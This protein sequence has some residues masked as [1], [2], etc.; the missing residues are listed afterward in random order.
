MHKC[1][2]LLVATLLLVASLTAC[3]SSNT[4]STNTTSPGGNST[5]AS[6]SGTG[7]SRLDIV[8]QRGKLICG[9]DGKIPGFSFVNE[10]GQ[11]SGLDVDVCKAVA[12]AVLGDPNAVEF[13]NLDSTERF[14]ALKAGEVDMLS[15]NTTWTISRDTSVGLEFAPTTFYDGQGMMVRQDSGIT[16]LEDFQGKAVCVE[17]GTTTELNLT[18]AMRQRGIQFETVTFQQADPAYAAY[19]EGRCQGMT[20]D[21]SQLVARRS[22]LPNPNEHILLDV[23]MSKEPLGPVTVNNDSTWFDVVKWTTFALFEAEELGVKQANVDQLKTSDNPNIKR[24]LGTEGDLGKGMGLSN[25]FAANAIKAV[26]NYGEVYER[27]LG[28]GSQ[29]KLPRGQN[30]LWTNGGLMYSPPFR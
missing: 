16:K 6:N 17:A 22:T 10:S 23:T 14:E 2:S 9:V 24:F 4:T 25:D 1:G 13:R 20:S 12:A 28:E 11:Y 15:R 29:F 3:E 21:K 18:D 30:A 19:A 5:P 7:Q 8:K 26:G 27:N